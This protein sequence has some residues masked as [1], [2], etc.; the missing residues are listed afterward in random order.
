[1]QTLVS[2][3]CTEGLLHW[4]VVVGKI[5]NSVVGYGMGLHVRFLLLV[6]LFLYKFKTLE[7]IM[8]RN[9]KAIPAMTWDFLEGALRHGRCKGF[10]GSNLA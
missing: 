5:G 2:P 3:G 8:A 4:D 10:C 7:G 9:L 6:C 1:M